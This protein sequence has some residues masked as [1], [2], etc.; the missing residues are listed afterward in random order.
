MPCLYNAGSTTHS[1]KRNYCL[2]CILLL[3]LPLPQNTYL[4][5]GVAP[6]AHPRSPFDPLVFL[7]V[8][9]PKPGAVKPLAYHVTNWKLC[10]NNLLSLLSLRQR[11]HFWWLSSG[12]QGQT[13]NIIIIDGKFN[14]YI[15]YNSDT[16]VSLNLLCSAQLLH[17]I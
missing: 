2:H 10:I 7:L 9:V 4:G 17:K 8:Q 16:Q 14:Y 12:Y 15:K 6:P 5:I 11:Q 1:E 13:Q 3:S